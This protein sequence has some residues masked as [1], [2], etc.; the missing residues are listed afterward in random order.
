MI[1][2]EKQRIIPNGNT[3]IEENDILIISAIGY[4]DDNSIS[5]REIE[6]DNGHEWCNQKLSKLSIPNDNIVVLIKRRNK[7]IIPN[8][9]IKVKADDTLVVTSSK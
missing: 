4:Y 6:I 8:G 7:T 5:L 9:D 1:Q 3:I 2:R